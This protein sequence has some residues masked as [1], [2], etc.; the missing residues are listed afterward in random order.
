MSG[1]D[2]HARHRALAEAIERRFDVGGWRLGDIELWP[3]AR[4]DLHLDMMRDWT[5]PG[6]APVAPRWRRAA[7]ALAVPATNLWRS[8]RDLAHWLPRPSSAHALLLGDGSSLDWSEAGW[9][10]RFGEPILAACDRMGR[11]TL[12]MQ[13]GGLRRLPWRRPTFAANQVAAQGALAARFCALRPILPDHAEVLAFLQREGVAA[14]SLALEAL[15]HRGRLVHTGAAAFERV[16][17]TVR[18]RVAFVVAWYAGLGPAFM[19]ACRRQGVLSVDLQHGPRGEAHQA[20]AWRGLPPGG[21]RVMPTAFWTWTQEEAARIRGWTDAPDAVWPLVLPGGNL[22]LA[23]FFDD[24]DPRTRAWDAAFDAAAGGPAEREI[25]VA[26]QPLPGQAAV[27][28]ALAAAIEASPPGW[29]WWIR[30]HPAATPDQDATA[31]PLLALAGPRVVIEPASRLPL[32][33]LLRRVSAVV[34]LASAAAGEAAAFGV[35]ALF[36]SPQARTLFAELIARGLAHVVEV[37]ALKARIA[38]LPPSPR[39]PPAIQPPPIDESLRRLEA[40]AADPACIGDRRC[41]ANHWND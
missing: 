25:L 3:L 35:P 36:L 27:W 29:R 26:L 37:D 30:R 9:Q 12:Q 34:S 23:P 11:R 24:D 41:Y 2:F 19:V 20:Y 28:R 1:A 38:A 5:G 40:L 13:G 39:R 18:P 22:Q 4:L 10:D 33:A 7:A 6:A 21:Y 32:P 14:P 15:A 31:G 16:L 8:R 17:R